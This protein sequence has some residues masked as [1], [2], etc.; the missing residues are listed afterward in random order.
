MKSKKIAPVEIAD[1][2]YWLGSTNVSDFLQINTY[3]V[4][5]NGK[6]IVIDPGP[7][8][9]F[10]ETLTALEEIAPKEDIFALVLSNQDPDICSSITSWENE[11]FNGKIIA[12]WRTGLFVDSYGLLNPIHNIKDDFTGPQAEYLSLDFISFPYLH[13]PGALLTYDSVTGTLFSSDLFGAFGST[14]NLYA[15]DEYFKRMLKYNKHFLLTGQNLSA[16]I[17]QLNTLDLKIIAPQHGCV[18]TDQHEKYFQAF[19]HINENFFPSTQGAVNEGTPAT[20]NAS[21]FFFEQGQELVTNREEN[22]VDPATEL[23]NSLFVEHFQPD[24]IASHDEGAI[25]YIHLDGMNDFNSEYGWEEGDKALGTLASILRENKPDN[26]F[27]F[28]EQSINLCLMIADAEKEEFMSILSSLQNTVRLSQD[29]IKEMTCS[30][31]VV[32]LKELSSGSDDKSDL[33]AKMLRNRLHTLEEMEAMSICDFSNKEDV[34]SSA[35]LVLLI[36]P[37]AGYAR[38][39]EEYFTSK[40][41]RIEICSNGGNAIYMIDVLRPDVVISEIHVPQIDGFRIRERML[42]IPEFRNIPALYLSYEKTEAIIHRANSLGVHNILKKPVILTELYW[43]V[44][45]ELKSEIIHG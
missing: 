14:G 35:T 44:I 8:K 13:S 45:S 20:D 39:I 19:R 1:S 29:F 37:E 25:A 26:S 6:G 18:I 15:D 28:R 11:G 42:N 34:R 22:L 32:G 7:R 43:L 21:L 33:A 17:S 24:F 16:A 31:A 5:R 12:H 10:K 4:Y 27:L 3:M 2:I 30:I 9:Y 41:I 23:Y 40:G 38:M 36:E